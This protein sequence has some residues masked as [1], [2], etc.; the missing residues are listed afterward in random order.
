MHDLSNPFTVGILE[1]GLAKITNETDINNYHPDYSD[2]SGN[3]FHILA[4]GRYQKGKGKYF[5][6]EDHGEYI[7]SAG[8]NEYEDDSEIAFALSRMYTAVSHRSNY[9]VAQFILPQC[10]EE[11]ESYSKVWLAMNDHNS[12]MYKWF[13]RTQA[14]KSSGLFNNWP[15][16]YKG[17]RPI[18][19]KQIYNT[20]QYVVELKRENQPL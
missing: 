5:L 2:Y 1:E 19:K 4:K 14:G 13:E 7:C 3:L 6:V 20:L 16:I 8:W 9:Y 18:G 10:L 15:D 11:V 12:I 17:F